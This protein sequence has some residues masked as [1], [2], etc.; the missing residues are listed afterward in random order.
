MRND[1]LLC[2]NLQLFAD[3]AG[4]GGDGAGTGVT[5]MNATSQKG[6]TGDTA[7]VVYGKQ[8][9]DVQTAN[10]QNT[11]GERDMNAEF[12]KL[13]KGEF[14][15]QYN[16]RVS[17]TVRQRLKS[18]DET[19][20]KYE[21]LSPVLE[22]LSNK[23]GVDSGNIEALSKAI[24]DDDSF[25]E[26]EALEKGITVQQLKEIRKMERENAALKKQMQEQETKENA[27]RLYAKWLDQAEQVSKIYPSF[28]LE[29]EMQ[30][31]KFV[32]LLRVPS[33]DVRT[34]YEVIHKDEIIPSAMAFTAQA[35]E[36][37][38]TNKIIAN[39]A[40][41]IENGIVPQSASLIKSDPSQLT[42]KD[43]QEIRK[44]VAAGD[45]IKF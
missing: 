21:A 28:D 8:D 26:D 11:D 13:I 35:V 31:P 29:S 2:I 10:A 40:R 45:T 5:G 44:R 12:E 27:S 33:V 22:M 16:D 37:K 32:D 19:V 38:L 6:V 9:A 23:Y 4:T 20:K 7:D 3:G 36:K 30:N 43:I 14:K 34:A 42:H 24:E 25:F 15:Q 18:T 1:K 17:N 41:P 39:G